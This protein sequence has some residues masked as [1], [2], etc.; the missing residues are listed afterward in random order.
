MSFSLFIKQNPFN[1]KN[2]KGGR[3]KNKRE[4]VKGGSGTT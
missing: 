3:E 2:K 4:T 1:D